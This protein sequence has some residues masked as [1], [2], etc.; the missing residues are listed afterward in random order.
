MRKLFLMLVLSFVPW[1]GGQVP[2]APSETHDFDFWLGDWEVTQPNGTVAGHSVIE[3][4]LDGR[5]IKESYQTPGRY[6]GQSLN[7]YNA[8]AK[9]WEQ[10]WVDNTGLALHLTGG[11]NAA[12]EMVLQGDRLDAEG[13]TVTDR[14]TWR[15][16]GDGTVQQRWESSEDG[17]ATWALAFDGHYRPRPKTE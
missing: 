8:P 4:I 10:Y 5:A 17:G 7:I 2:T 15:N 6:R 1:L 9:R 3:S 16:N 11:L 14:I 12:G 13:K